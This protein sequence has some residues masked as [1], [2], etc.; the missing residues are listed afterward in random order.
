VPRSGGGNRADLGG[1]RG[2]FRAASAE[3][4]L[5][6]G[7]HRIG[8]RSRPLLDTLEELLWG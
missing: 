6:A 8:S 1:L 4:Q 5:H 3:R 7:P 2:R